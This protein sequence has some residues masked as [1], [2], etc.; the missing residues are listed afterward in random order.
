MVKKKPKKSKKGGWIFALVFIGILIILYIYAESSPKT[1]SKYITPQST[2]RED[3]RMTQY[4]QKFNSLISKRNLLSQYSQEWN[5]NNGKRGG[6]KLNNAIAI[7]D[8]YYEQCKRT[9]YEIEDFDGW[10]KS[11]GNWFGSTFSQSKRDA[12]YDDFNEIINTCRS[13]VDLMD[14]NIDNMERGQIAEDVLKGLFNVLTG[15][16]I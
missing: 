12:L 14:E 1:G 13:N 8:R 9:E 4:K 6:D 7:R 15:G 10:L 2:P 3:Y 11:N 5:I 16:L